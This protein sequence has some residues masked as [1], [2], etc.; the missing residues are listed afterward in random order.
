MKK[1]RHMRLTIAVLLLVVAIAVPLFAGYC[2]DCGNIDCQSPC[3]FHK[4]DK[5][6]KWSHCEECV[7]YLYFHACTAC[8]WE[9]YVCCK[10]PVTPQYCGVPH[11]NPPYHWRLVGGE[12][13]CK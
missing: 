4:T 1:Q 2:L 10:D 3:S 7:V 8:R 11:C 5:P 9:R 12:W 13:E 6:E